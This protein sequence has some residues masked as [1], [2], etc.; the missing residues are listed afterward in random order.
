VITFNDRPYLAVKFTKDVN[1]LA[2]GLAGVK[3]ERGTALYDTI[4]FTLFYFNGVKGQRA[5]LLLSD[6]K[7]EGSRF[8]WEEALD[9]ARRAG[10]AI[11]PIG[12]GPQVEKP[13]LKKLAEE[14]GGRAFFLEDV[15]GLAPVYAAIEEELRSKYLIAYQSTNTS[16][17]D[18]FR[19][20]ELKVAKPGVEAKTM[21]G[22][23]P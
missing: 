2:S 5:I 9:Y 3:A 19:A 17:S 14:T 15:S 22:Y 8:G 18:G 12:L 20:V 11:Y 7:D 1:A 16:G 13:K 4:V 10:V 6:G 23:Y 21:R